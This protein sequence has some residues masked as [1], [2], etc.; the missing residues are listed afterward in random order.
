MNEL[1]QMFATPHAQAPLTVQSVLLSLVLAFVLAQFLGAVYAWTFRGM[2]YSGTFVQSLS[3]GAI[4]CAMLMLAIN[5][6][7]AAGLGIAGSLA[8]I[9]FRTAIRE[10]R[11]MVFVF[12]AMG[13]GIAAGLRAYTAA[14]AGT[15][16]F[17]IANAVMITSEF[18]RRDQVDA[19]V[20][21]RFPRDAD[22]SAITQALQKHSRHFALVTLRDVAQGDLF[23]HAYQL[24]FNRPEQSTQIVHALQAVPGTEDVCLWSQEPTIQL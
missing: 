5:N 16:I 22:Q 15:A 18:G 24:Q 19:L 23:E 2:S 9:R 1:H 7:V 4:V 6:S 13:A 10:P 20:R 17:C 3:L 21:F 12:A 14:V 11:D 8:I